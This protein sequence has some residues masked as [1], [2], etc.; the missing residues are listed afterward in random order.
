MEPVTTLKGVG[1]ERSAMLGR[2]G[3]HTIQ[4][5]LLHSPS[6]YEDRTHFARISE[7]N[8]GSQGTVR[9]H[10]VA[11]GLKQ[12]GRH[13]PALFEL[14]LQDDSGRLHCRW[15]NQPYLERHFEEAT[16]VVVH[17]TVKQDQPRTMDHPETEIVDGPDDELIHTGRITPIYPLTEGLAQRWLRKLLWLTIKHHSQQV[18]EPRPDL[19][20]PG[21]KVPA[22]DLKEHRL[23]SRRDAIQWLHFPDKLQQTEIARLRLAADE[24]I[25]LQQ[26]FKDRRVAFAKKA[27][28]LPCGGNNR[29]I[30][31]FLVRLGFTLTEAQTKVLRT[32][33][34]DL[35]GKHPM[36]RLL[37]GDVGA[38]KTVVAACAALMAIESGYSVAVMAPTEILAEQHFRNF[39]KWFCPLS[40]PIGLHTGSTTTHRAN[41]SPGLTVGTHALIHEGFQQRNLGLVVIDE[42]HKF[43]VAQREQLVRKG[44]YPH[45]LVMTATPIPRSLGLTIYGDLEISV[46]EALPPGRG[47]IR[48]FIRSST[49]LPHVLGYVKKRLAEGKRAYIVCPR[50]EETDGNVKAVLKEFR[51]IQESLAPHKVEMLHGRM[52]PVEKES[53]MQAFR[54]GAAPVLLSTALVEV[55]LDVPEA[56]LI[57]IQN[58]ER[59]GLSQL[60][61]LRGRIGRGGDDSEC[62]L[63]TDTKDSQ[64]LERLN[65][66]LQT[67]DGFKIAD[68]DLALRG[69]GEL[70]GQKQSGLPELKFGDLR[71]DLPLLTAAREW[72][73]NS[74][75]SPSASEYTPTHNT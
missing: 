69:P 25:D 73:A 64:S 27:M 33:R 17:G 43:G 7:L 19:E 11:S 60:H 30:R 4:E 47:E 13:R 56:T 5:L 68:A 6:R 52:T 72:V 35:A 34:Q 36:R 16:E 63:I 37:Q 40:I 41:E 20:V 71:K 53:A 24:F 29:L 23:P 45:V 42:Q 49:S 65:V 39:Q 22:G 74:R 58:A 2:L 28:A 14:I 18:T 70:L 61:Q 21:K 12:L 55:G 31:P 62:I 66:L 3:I 75:I 48:T 10:V 59:F 46:I 15:W 51:G 54:Y 57:V 44:R 38:G 26:R 67:R 50:V 9:G 32:I 8:K 1:P